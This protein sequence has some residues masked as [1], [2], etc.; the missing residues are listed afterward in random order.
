MTQITLKAKDVIKF[1]QFLK[2]HNRDT[3]FLAKD[4]GAYIGATAG[5]NA[6]GTFE[7]I[8]HYF[9]GCNPDKDEF[10]DETSAHKFGWDDF[11]AQLPAE[12]MHEAA[13]TDCLTKAVLNVTEAGKISFDRYFKRA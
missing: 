12:W 2:R 4:H 8:I 6:D 5:S 13:E 3:F 11:G 10:F 1:S 7:R 9:A